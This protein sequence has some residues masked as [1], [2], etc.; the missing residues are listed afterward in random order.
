[1]KDLLEQLSELKSILESADEGDESQ[2]ASVKDK[3]NLYARK[4]SKTDVYIKSLGEIKI[5]NLV[6]DWEFHQSKDKLKSM[7]NTMIEDIEIDGILG[8][9]NTEIDNVLANAKQ[10]EEEIDKI[11]KRLLREEEKVDELK[12]KVELTDKRINFQ[13]VAESNIKRSWFWLGCSSLVF[14]LILITMYFW[15]NIQSEF[16]NISKLAIQE[17][18]SNDMEIIKI[19]V[20]FEFIRTLFLRV[21]M[22]S[23]SIY[24]LIFCLRNYSVQLHNYTINTHKANSLQSALSLLNTANTSEGKDKLLLQATEA[25]FTHQNTGYS[26]ENIPTPNLITSVIENINPKI[27]K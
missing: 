3:L 24:I 18:G 25:I 11:T 5:H 10:K 16:I 8:N 9:T 1:M 21:L 6:E 7:V 4:Y 27:E 14:A 13:I 15:F 23:L 17:I 12:K 26:K 22:T 19:T 2:L 20:M